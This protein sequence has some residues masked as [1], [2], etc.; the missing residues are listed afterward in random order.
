MPHIALGIRNF[1]RPLGLFV[2]C[3]TAVCV[4]AATTLSVADEKNTSRNLSVVTPGLTA[5]EFAKV[6]GVIFAQAL[7]DVPGKNLVIVALEFPPRP[8]KEVD[9]PEQCPGHRHPGSAYVYVTKGAMRQ[10]VAGK[11]VELVHAGEG[12]F[13]PSGE[14]HTVSENASTTE[15]ASAIAIHIVPDGAPILIP[16]DKCKNP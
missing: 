12:F 15:P 5:K 9:P 1:A 2:A 8:Q 11:P 6:P 16:N 13:E 7:A 3:A 10:G 4:T 14:L